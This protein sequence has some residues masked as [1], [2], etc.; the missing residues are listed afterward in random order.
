[1]VFFRASVLIN[2]VSGK[3]NK[4]RGNTGAI[5]TVIVAPTMAP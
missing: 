3:C 5:I 4:S 1:V 2:E